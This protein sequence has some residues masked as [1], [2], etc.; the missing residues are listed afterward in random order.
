M[1]HTG[2]DAIFYVRKSGVKRAHFVDNADKLSSTIRG[3][4]G[5][6]ARFKSEDAVATNLKERGAEVL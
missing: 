5:D 2:A 6:L 1:Q 4:V 3:N